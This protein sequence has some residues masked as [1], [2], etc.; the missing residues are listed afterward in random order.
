MNLIEAI[1]LGIVQGLTEFLPVSS[2][3][4]LTIGK[5]LLGID[6]SNLAF[7]ITVH[8]ATVLSTIV[9][10]RKEV[11]ELIAGLFK[12]KMNEETLYIFKIAV[13]MIPIFIVGIFFKDF[14]E[15]LFGEGLL[16][17][18]IA[19]LVTS[20]LLLLSAI[21][22][23][24]EK[25]ITFRNAFVI[26]IAQSIAVIP[27]LSRSGATISTGLL[28]GVKRENIAKFSFLM[29]LV[30]ILGEVFLELLSGELSEGKTGIPMFALVAGFIAAFLSGLFAC[31]TMIAL[32]KRTKLKGFALYCAIVGIVAIIIVYV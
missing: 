28:L 9:A 27:G 10:F 5:E 8:A 15:S 19:L 30:P 32:V 18:G 13:S 21:I 6:S 11:A 3:G 22:K 31:K 25:G 29:V 4:H 24:K 20:S 12:F 1:I 17:V 23:P 14:V 26:G 16:V 7:E 2:S